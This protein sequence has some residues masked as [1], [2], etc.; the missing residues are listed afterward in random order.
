MPLLFLCCFCFYRGKIISVLNKIPCKYE[1][2][3]DVMS[4]NLIGI[5]PNWS[6]LK[7]IACELLLGQVF[8]EL[9]HFE[10]CLSSTLDQNQYL[11]PPRNDPTSRKEYRIVPV[12]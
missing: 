2:V 3:K 10:F 11:E 5:F 6:F 12:T 9:I 4:Y 7:G 1:C 8:K